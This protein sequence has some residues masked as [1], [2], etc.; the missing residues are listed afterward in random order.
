MFA[1]NDA[2]K[3][4][5]DKDLEHQVWTRHNDIHSDMITVC[6]LMVGQLQL[7]CNGVVTCF[8]KFFKYIKIIKDFS[9]IDNTSIH[10]IR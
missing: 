4:K 5:L 3:L 8:H 7:N 1:F 6:I 9:F 10:R 2:A